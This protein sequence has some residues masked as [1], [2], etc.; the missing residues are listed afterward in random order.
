MTTERPSPI[1]LA[2]T[3]DLVTPRPT[4]TASVVREDERSFWDSLERG[5]RTPYPLW[6]SGIPLPSDPNGPLTNEVELVE[7]GRSRRFDRRNAGE[8]SNDS[9]ANRRVDPVP[10]VTSTGHR[11]FAGAQRQ[12]FAAC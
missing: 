12:L 5:T 3:W 9:V 6:V 4:A 8:V 11:G 10:M 1:S 2:V 7:L